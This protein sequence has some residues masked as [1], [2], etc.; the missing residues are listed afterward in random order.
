MTT[1]ASML[2]QLG[3]FGFCYAAIFR[4]VLSYKQ[5][6]LPRLV[7][8]RTIVGMRI[9]LQVVQ[10]TCRYEN[11]R[12]VFA[13]EDMLA[14][15][16]S[17]LQLSLPFK[18]RDH[19]DSGEADLLGLDLGWQKGFPVSPS[20]DLTFLLD[21]VVLMPMWTCHALP[22]WFGRVF[23][24]RPLQGYMLCCWHHSPCGAGQG[25]NLGVIMVDC[26]CD[27]CRGLRPPG[28]PL[29]LVSWRTKNLNTL[30]EVVFCKDRTLVLDFPRREI[31]LNDFLLDR[32][33]F[34]SKSGDE[35]GEKLADYD[36][37]LPDFSS[38]LSLLLAKKKHVDIDWKFVHQQLS[39]ELRAELDDWILDEPGQ[40]EDVSIYTDGSF[41]CTVEEKK[42]GWAFLAIGLW[43][44][45]SYILGYDW[46]IVDIDPLEEGWTGAERADSKAAEATAILRALEWAFSHNLQTTYT[47]YFDSQLAGFSSSGVYGVAPWD[48]QHRA[49]RAMAKAFEAFHRPHGMTRWK[50]VKAHNG[51]LGNEI[52]DIFAKR[53]FRE[54]SFLHSWTCPDYSPFLFGKRFPLEYLWMLWDA[55]SGLSNGGDRRAVLLL[56]DH[57]PD[58]PGCLEEKLPPELLNEVEDY[59]AEVTS[60]LSSF[61]SRYPHVIIGTD[62]N[63]H[64][65]AECEGCIGDAGLESKENLGGRLFRELLIRFELFLP[66]TFADI[67]TGKH[68]T[69]FHSAHDTMSR[70]DYFALP[71]AWRRA[72]LGTWVFDTLDI[73]K[74]GID[75]LPVALTFC[76]AFQVLSCFDKESE[77]MPK[78]AI[79][80]GDSYAILFVDISNAFYKV[81]RQHVVTPADDDRGARELFGSLG[82][83]LQAFCEF[84][85]LLR[86][87]DALEAAEVPQHL[88]ALF[89]EFFT[90]TW[91]MIRGDHVVTQTRKGSRPGDAFADLVFSFALTKF[92][93]RALD[94]LQMEF[95]DLG[96]WW[97]GEK[98]IYPEGD[99]HVDLGPLTPIWADDL[100]FAV[101]DCAPEMLIHKIQRVTAVLFENLLAAGLTPNLKKGK[102]EILMDLRG[103]G[104]L[105]IRRDL[106][107]Q[108]NLLRVDSRYGPFELHLVGAYKPV[109]NGSSE[110][111]NPSNMTM[112]R[113]RY[114]PRIF[115]HLFAGVW[116]TSRL[117]QYPGPL[118][119]ALAQI[120]L[121]AQADEGNTEVPDW[122][123]AAVQKLVAQFDMDAPMG[124][125]YNAAAVISA[126]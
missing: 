96:I 115:A 69:W 30:D 28:N 44:E 106:L 26:W 55:T 93:Q 37:P 63:A 60:L 67:H 3:L 107:S 91:F 62:A 42:A 95:N 102:S 43:E 113:V 75:H 108:E 125:D 101:R 32:S 66:S 36:F 6:E 46:G 54:Q 86:Q 103:P 87:P 114:V 116:N 57:L 120:F 50:H 65:D 40:V 88:K 89:R 90:S 7:P 81:V 99:F 53:A 9:D 94:Q 61:C 98:T 118:C 83:P 4:C 77:E 15:Q 105:A 19:G 74:D 79:A 5:Q 13:A 78:E 58:V 45:E 72:K 18:V 84:Q 110:M 100:A 17:F 33:A 52:V 80:S 71:Q 82:L 47:F 16:T 35:K 111:L 39:S 48:R 124:P 73:V 85:E 76:M 104:S 64:F 56:R 21:V 70:C 117:K 23:D 68:A 38:L 59:W 27:P 14:D 34:P 122:F 109:V 121:D 41:A 49:L 24:Q 11:A 12:Q 112:S 1:T 31:A 25:A 92:V 119:K 123:E 97:N 20:R 8:W 22:S 29:E 126:N 51:T 2:R 10:E